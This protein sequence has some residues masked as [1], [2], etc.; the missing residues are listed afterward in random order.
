MCVHRSPLIPDGNSELFS[1]FSFR[2]IS[3][4]VEMWEGELKRIYYE[5]AR[6]HE[7]PKVISV[8]CYGATCFF[9]RLCQF[10]LFS[11]SPPTNTNL[12]LQFSRFGF[13]VR[14]GC[15]YYISPCFTSHSTAM[16]GWKRNAGRI[17]VESFLSGLWFSMDSF[18]PHCVAMDSRQTTLA[19]IL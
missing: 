10:P 5:C 16:K 15:S 18:L 6:P 1:C 19:C 9:M 12:W 7:L 3:L 17:F 4:R 8:P 14:L 13:I 11:P 2:F